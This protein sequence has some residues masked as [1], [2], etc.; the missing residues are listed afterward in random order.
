MITVPDRQV[1]TF[2]RSRR[3]ESTRRG[4][5]RAVPV[6]LDP[7]QEVTHDPRARARSARRGR[8]A[9][10]R[11]VAHAQRD[12]A[13]GQPDRQRAADGRRRRLRPDHR[14]RVAGGHRVRPEPH[15]HHRAVGDGRE[16]RHRDVVAAL[17]ARRAPHVGPGGLRRRRQA[18]A[19]HGGGVVPRHRR[20]GAAR[21]AHADDEEQGEAR[22][23][24]R[25]PA[26]HLD[27]APRRRAVRDQPRALPVRHA[28][29]PLH[30]RLVER[31]R[32]LARGARARAR[33]ASTSSTSSSRR[34]T[35]SSAST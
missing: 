22:G 6:Q 4:A 15:Q 9:G 23:H 29:V 12:A 1:R 31:A 5:R 20:V 34:S 11:A 28:E 30:D 7:R 17:V 3:S 27:A 18:D 16:L 33:R 24:E 25:R 8:R 2:S 10:G 21:R 26:L 19:R 35:S 32:G 13:E 14:G